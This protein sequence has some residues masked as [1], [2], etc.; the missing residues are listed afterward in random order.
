MDDL[1]IKNGSRIAE[2][3]VNKSILITGS[4]GF[5]GKVLV[6]KLLTSCESLVKIYLLIRP[7][8][9]KN[10][11][12]RLDELFD[13]KL[14]DLTKTKIENFR[15][16]ICLVDG[17]LALPNLGL[18]DQDRQMLIDN[19]NIV[20]NSAASIKFNDPLNLAVNMNIE[21]TKKLINLAYKMKHLEVFVHVSTAYVNC[22]CKH[23]DEKLYEPEHDPEWLIKQIQLI[24]ENPVEE[25]EKTVLFEKM[26]EILVSKEKP[27]TYVFTKKI[28][29]SLVESECRKKNV[30]VCIVRPSVIGSSWKEPFAGW[31]DT[32]FGP[33]FA[34]CTIGT[35]LFTS[36]IGNNDLLCDLV[37][38]DLTVNML[39]ASSWYVGSQKHNSKSIPIF[40]YTSGQI[41]P[42]YWRN[43]SG[44][45]NI[46]YKSVPFENIVFKPGFHYTTSS[47]T[48]HLKTF[49]YQLVPAHFLDFMA[50]ISKKRPK[51]VKI[52]EKIKKYN[53]T[54]Q[55]FT[56][57]EWTFSN[58]NIFMLMDELE[59][60]D[61]DK[62]EFNFDLREVDWKEYIFN[63]VRGSKLYV[64]KE[65]ENRIDI[66][67]DRLNRVSTIQNIFT[68]FVI[69]L[70]LK[71]F[72][73]D[74]LIGYEF[75]E[76]FVT[77]AISLFHYL[78]GFVSSNNID[79][80][81]YLITHN[82]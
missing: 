18:S 16:K 43:L 2:Y 40:N 67:K 42:F 20:F 34:F 1:I 29:E 52:Q 65:K 76:D 31:V 19:V 9:G 79:L 81:E 69:L 59:K 21:S 55:Y 35:G 12:E 37:P 82:G 48:Y 57:R 73:F 4:T 80:Q 15:E 61:S 62:K 51:M 3:Y 39:I 13:S 7:K 77:S 27:N 50:K 63:Y 8:K 11:A 6:A 25:S 38:V 53:D 75:L 49:F 14:F 74:T 30:P 28:A 54:I 70:V 10:A 72:L 32:F 5:V 47:L 46:A 33:T 71:Y 24:E 44:Y 64:M 66:C 60:N 23:L 36:M 41:N 22:D 78:V 17:D 26:R 45:S 68:A 56:T 58:H